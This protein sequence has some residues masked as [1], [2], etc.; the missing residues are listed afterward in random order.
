MDAIFTFSEEE[1][2]TRAVHS[3]DNSVNSSPSAAIENVGR[4]KVK[5][6]SSLNVSKPPEL[7]LRDTTNA[8]CKSESSPPNSV[9]KKTTKKEKTSNS[10]FIFGYII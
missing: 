6:P 7:V 5:R 2:N 8:G 10:Q 9:Q 1:L 4:P 3:N